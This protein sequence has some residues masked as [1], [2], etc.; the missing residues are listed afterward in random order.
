MGIA[1]AVTVAARSAAEADVAA[2]LIANAVDLPGHAKI[3]RQP[4]TELSPDSDLGSRKVTVDVGPL[5][6]CD[7]AVALEAGAE[8]AANFVRRGLIQQAVLLLD[9][10]TRHVGARSQHLLAGAA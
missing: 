8:T 10:E 7:V 4:A 2:T 5:E 6:P 1:D 9:G 3:T